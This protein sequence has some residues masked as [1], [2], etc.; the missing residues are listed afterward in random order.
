M[1][2]PLILSNVSLFDGRG[3]E[4]AEGVTVVVADGLIQEVHTDGAGTSTDGERIDGGGGTLL[5]GLIDAHV[6]IGA[7]DVYFE[8]QAD[9]YSPSLMAF[10]MAHRLR[11]LLDLGYTTVRDCGGTDWGFKQA[12]GQRLIAGPRIVISNRML[13]QTGGHGDMRTRA[14]TDEPCRGGHYGMVF[15]IADGVSEVRRAVREQVR[16]GA[17]FV[18]VMASGG[19]ASPTD[20]L[21]RPQY[22]EEEL[23]IVVEEAEMAGVYVAAH[24]LPSIAITR[25]VRAGA[26]TIEHGNFL[27]DEAAGLMAA[28]DTFLVPTVATY[29]MASRHPERYDYPPEITEKVDSAANAALHSLEVA[30]RH[31]V[32]MGSGSD[33]LGEEIAW[34]NHELEL[35][36]EVLGAAATLRSATSVNAELIGRDDLGVVEPGRRADLL[37]VNGDPL[38]DISVL[39][40]PG[41][42]R[43][44]MKDGEPHVNTL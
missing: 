41:A 22:S 25:A 1:P 40:A 36:A 13:S 23:R 28:H 24:A 6:H 31:G 10:K 16:M 42:V 21:D 14:Q 4:P 9:R 7:V 11:H 37:I 35:K 26:R 30:A 8:T 19:A 15:S 2:Q 43:L 33:L 38:T 27:D 34:L 44:V 39:G 12:V 29:V 17:D 5:P 20:K 32:R 18:K 3:T